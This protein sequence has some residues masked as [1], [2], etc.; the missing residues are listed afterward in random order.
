M[1]A[2]RYCLVVVDSSVVQSAGETEYPVSRVCREV[3]DGILRICHHII[4][5]NAI[6]EEWKRHH[7]RY[8]R[9]W[10]FQMNGRK[11]I[12]VIKEDKLPSLKINESYFTES[13]LDAL[14]KDLPLL[15]AACFGDGI[16][17][18]RDERV[19]DICSKYEKQIKLTKSIRWIIPGDDVTKCLE[20]L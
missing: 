3:L 12:E 16:I 6:R 8:T 13:E 11:K 17:I 2:K 19:R 15:E 9:K 5:T 4:I 1:K 20:E 18:T 10:R 7:S 14:K